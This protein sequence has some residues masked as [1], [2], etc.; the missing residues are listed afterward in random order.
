[1]DVSGIA[2]PRYCA[3]PMPNGWLEPDAAFAIEDFED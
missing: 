3:I 2:S 1:M